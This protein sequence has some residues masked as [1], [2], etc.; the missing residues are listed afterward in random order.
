MRFLIPG[1]VVL[2][3]GCID[4]TG[5]VEQSAYV[6]AVDVYVIALQ[7][8]AVGGAKIPD[9]LP[10]LAFLA[11][12]FPAVEQAYQINCP[13]GGVDG[14][15]GGVRGWQALRP[16]GESF[17]IE[18]SAGR[19][20]EAG[21]LASGGPRVALIKTATN[22]TSVNAEWEPDP[23]TGKWQWHYMTEFVDGQL[24]QLPPDSRVAGVFLVGFEGDALQVATARAVSAELVYW[25]MNF[26]ERYGDVPVVVSEVSAPALK[27]RAETSQRQWR[28]AE[29]VPGLIIVETGD[30]TYRDG[31]HYDASSS[32]ELGLR[33]A[34]AMRSN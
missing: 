28:A 9:L 16:R 27:Y 23:A 5:T 29:H 10:A 13:K 2:L 22:G 17:G 32:V 12:P 6:D 30:L 20:L 21:R 3:G 11:K 34:A 19:A 8:N 24:A 4:P 18:L 7:S 26:R 33:M 15:C 1:V 14:P 31:I 25:T